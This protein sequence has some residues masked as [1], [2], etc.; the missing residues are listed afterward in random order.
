M[1]TRIDALRASLEEPLLVLNGTNVR[2]LTGFAS[3]NAALLVSHDELTLYADF[4]YASAGRS[5][6]GVRFVE[7]KRAL[8]AD[9]AAQL[10]GRI[11]FE[12]ETLTYA[13]FETLKTGGLEL[14]PRSGLVE[15]LR[16]V[17][18]DA[19]IAAITRA[20]EITAAAFAR[21]AEEPFIGRR[22]RELA[23][24]LQTFLHDLGSEGL[25]FEVGLGAGPSGAL[26][27]AHPSDRVVAEGDLV[28]VDAGGMIGGY[29][30]DCTRTFA[31]GPIARRLLHAYSVCHEAQLAALAAIRPGTSG[32]DADRAAREVIDASGFGENFGHGLGHGVGLLV[33]EAPRLST[34][35]SD[36]LEVGDVFSVEPG[37][38]LPDVAGIRIED[39]VVLRDD[40]PEILTGYTK[41]LVSVQ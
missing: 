11:A 32:V 41:E 2:Y 22:E 15:R 6:E 7:T 28:V 29:C 40:G 1:N 24:K 5:I 35:S 33:H 17:K 3:S 16:A 34:E 37:I 12:P 26:P 13:G 14:V 18:D 8:L 36:T 31:A 4:R 39:L 9:L 19:E 25:A 38:Y 30:S 27:H 23:W 21:L 10:S 20:S